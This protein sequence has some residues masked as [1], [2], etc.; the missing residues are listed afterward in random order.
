MYIHVCFPSDSL[1][2]L[3]VE[4]M[5]ALHEKVNIV[6]VLAKADGLTHA[7][8]C[9]KK[10]KVRDSEIQRFPLDL[11]HFISLF[12]LLSNILLFQCVRPCSPDPRG[13]QAVRDQHLPVSRL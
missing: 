4:C 10:M 7:E 11:F 9:R 6:P 2:P 8:V 3:D 12:L 5:R 13:D 1:R